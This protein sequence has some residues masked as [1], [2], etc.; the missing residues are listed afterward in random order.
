VQEEPQPA[1]TELPLTTPDAE[2]PKEDPFEILHLAQAQTRESLSRKVHVL[3]TDSRA[4]FV[5]HCLAGPSPSNPPV[6]LVFHPNRYLRAWKDEGQCI[7]LL[8]DGSYVTRNHAVVESIHKLDGFIDNLVIT[9]PCSTT[10][11]ALSSLKDNIDNRTTVCLIQDGMG[12]VE[13]L[14]AR[15]FTDIWSRPSYVL[16]HM[17]HDLDFVQT[18]RRFSLAERGRGKLCLTA[19]YR[20]VKETAGIKFHPPVERQTKEANL[21]RTLTT[22]PDLWAGGYSLAQFL[23]TKMPV[24][25]FRSVIEPVAAMLD[26]PYGALWTSGEA[27]SLIRELLDEIYEVLLALPEV[28]DAPLLVQ[29][30]RVGAI[31]KSCLKMLR[32]KE[33]QESRIGVKVHLGRN[34]DIGYLTGWFVRRGA[35]H[36]LDCPRSRMLLRMVRAKWHAHSPDYHVAHEDIP[37]AAAR[38]RETTSR[39]NR[40]V[41]RSEDLYCTTPVP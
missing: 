29:D 34:P 4:M 31:T 2:A 6:S 16:G 17:T 14:N 11:R 40:P 5:A 7:N 19:Y 13:E 10:L 30:I 28:K 23:R 25:V 27:R 38:R 8:R 37:L 26:L 39:P 22:T 35:D 15:L 21:M 18:D 33:A 1:E 3:G 41:G 32:R 24:M 9:A 20:N 12:V 36:S